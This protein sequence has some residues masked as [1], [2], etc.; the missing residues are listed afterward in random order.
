LGAEISS[1]AFAS[2]KVGA[3]S[4]SQKKKKR[5]AEPRREV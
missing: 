1:I 4:S 3:K 2:E 5:K